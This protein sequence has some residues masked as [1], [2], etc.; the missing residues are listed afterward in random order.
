[1][2]APITIPRPP[3]P[4]ILEDVAVPQ[5]LL[6]DLPG[7]ALSRPMTKG[8]VRTGLGVAGGRIC[9]PEDIPDAPRIPARD[10]V[11]LPRLIESHVHLDKSDTIGETGAGDGTLM[12]AIGTMGPVM[13]GWSVDHYRARMT[14]AV[15]EALAAGVGAIRT[16][17]DCMD[18][19]ETKAGWQA[20]IEVAQLFEG[21]MQITP[22]ALAALDR[23]AAGDFDKRCAQVARAGGVLG[24]F[25]PPDGAAPATLDAFLTGAARHGLD[26]DFHVDEH[27]REVPSATVALAEAVLRTGYDGRVL[28]GHTCRLGLMNAD[29]LDRAVDVIARSGI[30]VASLP[31]TNLYLQD[32]Q[33]GRTPT[34]RGMAPIHELAAR[35]VPVV[36][37]TDNV[38]DAFFPMGCYDLLSLFSDA[39]YSLHLDDDLAGWIRAITDIP[40]RILGLD[41]AGLVAPGASAD[42][43]LAPARNWSDL[44]V[45]RPEDRTVL[46]G[47]RDIMQD[48]TQ[49]MLRREV[50]S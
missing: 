22:V 18:L 50:V 1:M 40:A 43:I 36:F 32:R 41:G 9:R 48:N 10:H 15:T 13:Q 12:G 46:I 16:H 28:A 44:L 2:T 11:A 19:P 27:L 26:V 35:G 30:A 5:T 3:L 21:R 45:C 8:L 7:L 4:Y 37:G 31:R 17:V 29:E 6:R 25:I 47:G 23:T 42:L 49:D 33:A 24:A 34:R 38:R 20:G 14:R 39:A